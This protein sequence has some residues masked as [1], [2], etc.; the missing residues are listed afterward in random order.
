MTASR[1]IAYA[2]QIGGAVALALGVAFWTGRLYA[3]V[4]VHMTLGLIVVLGL[5][6]LAVL[7][8]RRGG[9]PKLALAAIAW[10]VVLLAVGI[11][12]TS[13]LV[14]P[15]H[16][17]IEVAYLLL[18]LGAVAFAIPLS[19]LPRRLEARDTNGIGSE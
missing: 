2:V 16:W 1:A 3:L 7:T 12:Q 6:I 9:S 15:H 17:V 13:M 8:Y 10:G 19:V 14:G 11:G 18:G 5:W 4:A